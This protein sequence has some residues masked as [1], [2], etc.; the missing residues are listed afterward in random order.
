[1]R[2]ALPACAL[3]LALA[4]LAQA[5]TS[6][7]YQER[8]RF[9]TCLGQ[10]QLDASEA[11]E[12]AQTWRLEGGGW[13]AEVC[14]ARALIELGEPEVGADILVSL[15]ER[16]PVG[17]IDEE[18]SE[19]FI[20]AGDTRFALGLVDEAAAAYDAAL[21]LMP[22]SIPARLARARLLADAGQWET[23]EA[24]AEA[25]ITHAPYLAAGWRY[26]GQS[27]L[28]RGEL[29]LAWQDM[30]RARQQE[31]DDIPS[32]L[33]RGAILEARRLTAD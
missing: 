25:L 15:A 30:E 28:G 17:M 32:L 6:A 9:D 3:A 4:P 27:R 24:D 1:M 16:Q 29:D 33:L 12:R 18:Q 22:D 13:P 23:L 10:I 5:Q 19:L 31:P 7:A 11:L 26:R 20:L 2:I 14:E 21:A 8:I